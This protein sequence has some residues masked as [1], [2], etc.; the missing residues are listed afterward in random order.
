MAEKFEKI[1]EIQ[2]D[3][4]G[5]VWQVIGDEV[6]EYY[7]QGKVSV[8]DDGS[9]MVEGGLDYASKS[10]KLYMNNKLGIE[11]TT[12]GDLNKFITEKIRELY[13]TL[14]DLQGKSPVRFRWIVNVELGHVDSDWTYYDQLTPEE[15][16]NNA[17]KGWRGDEMWEAQIRENLSRKKGD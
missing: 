9:G 8:A 10:G 7:I 13:N 2:D 15:L 12:L 11:K 16:K 1:S 6:D 14:M 17:W 3:I 5:A 4:L